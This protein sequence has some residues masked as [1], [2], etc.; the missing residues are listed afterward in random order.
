M[1]FFSSRN[2]GNWCGLSLGG[3]GDVTIWQSG[4]LGITVDAA[5]VK[6]GA[7]RICALRIPSLV[8]TAASSSS[9][10]D[11]VSIRGHAR[12]QPELDR[13]RRVVAD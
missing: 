9:T 12:R 13:D 10:V 2:S 6:H 1:P 5:S 3:R 8:R 7:F 11:D 4:D